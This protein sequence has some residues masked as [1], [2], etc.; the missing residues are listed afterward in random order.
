MSLGTSAIRRWAPLALLFLLGG[1]VTWEPA[2]G[3]PQRLI[4]D[5]RPSSVRVT[6]ADGV[7]RTLKSPLFINDSIVSAQAPPPGAV[8]VPPRVG[9]PASDVSLLELPRFSKGKTALLIAA[10]AGASLTW[11]GIQGVGLGSEPRPDPLPKDTAFS[12]VGLVRLVWS[13]F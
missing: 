4:E 9:V 6:D 1:C 8:V 2:G 3:P 5:T 11:A 12:L 7:Q 13:G 10:I